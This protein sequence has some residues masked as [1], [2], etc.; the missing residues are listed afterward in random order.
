MRVVAG[1]ASSVLV[2]GGDWTLRMQLPALSDLESALAGATPAALA[3]DCTGIGR[4]DSRLVGFVIR[5]EALCKQQEASVSREGLPEGARRLLAL[6]ESVP[7][8]GV[9]HVEQDAGFLAAIGKEAI[10]FVRSSGELLAFFGEVVVAMV[11]VARGR[12]HFRGS[13]L[14]LL[15]QRTGAEA[16]PI[17]T[18]ISLLVGLILAYIGAMQLEP[19]GA[20]VFVANLVGIAM[21]REMAAMMTGIIMAGRTGAAIAAQLGTMTVN[22]EMDALRTSAVSPM[23]FLVLPRIVALVLMMPLLTIYAN[24][25]GMLGGSITALALLDVSLREYFVQTR[26]GLDLADFATGLI[27]AVV[28]G[29][30][31]AVSGCLRGMQCGRSAAAVGDATTSAVV[32]GI[33]FIV[34]ASAT[35]T[36][37]FQVLGV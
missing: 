1:A 3:F 13:E 11:R 5:V 24:A 23:E 18:L 19:F 27:K 33:V 22:E 37:V 36:V 4:W 25:M 17:V 8:R 15:M 32:T 20:E 28:Y 14:L 21:A 34:I 7:D 35:L 30:I 29:A 10:A 26:V 6:A 12:A 31:V 16:L 9:P 2:L